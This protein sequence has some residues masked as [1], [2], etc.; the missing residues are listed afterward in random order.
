M[1]CCRRRVPL[2]L[3]AVLVPHVFPDADADATQAAL[4]RCTDTNEARAAEASER[5]VV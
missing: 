1:R 2:V 4:Q 5:W 3:V